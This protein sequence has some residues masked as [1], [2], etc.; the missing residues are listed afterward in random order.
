MVVICFFLECLDKK[1]LLKLWPGLPSRFFWTF[2]RKDVKALS[3]SSQV[4][5]FEKK[6]KLRWNDGV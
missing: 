3:L 4:S 2:R 5:K 1:L 6:V